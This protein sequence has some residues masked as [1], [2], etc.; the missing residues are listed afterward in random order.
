VNEMTAGPVTV[1]DRAADDSAAPSGDPI[2]FDR[3]A[4]ARRSAT[5]WARVLCMNPYRV[6]LDA[7]ARLVDVGACSIGLR[8]PQPL[9]IGEVV[10][11]RLAPFRVR[12]RTGVVTRCER[13][14][15]R[16]TYR[17]AVKFPTAL[18]AA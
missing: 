12:G 15:D 7:T 1:L 10:E 11:I 18:A 5:G 3:R 13:D 8:S 6:F 9:E 14:G 17:I 2:P 4:E 16:G